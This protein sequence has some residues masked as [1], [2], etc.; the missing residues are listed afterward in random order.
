MPVVYNIKK[1]LIAFS[2]AAMRKQQSNMG[3]VILHA[4]LQRQSTKEMVGGHA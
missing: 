2:H 1:L 3:S 4:E